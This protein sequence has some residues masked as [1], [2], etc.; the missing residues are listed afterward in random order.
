[1]DDWYIAAN[2]MKKQAE[3]NR[4]KKLKEKQELEKFIARFS[5]NASKAKQATSRQKQLEKLDIADIQ[6]SSRRD[7]SIMFKPNREIGN[8]VL[9]VID[10]YKSYEDNK[11]LNGVSFKAEKSDKIAIIGG[12]G[13]GK[14]TLLEI[15]IG[16]LEPDSGTIKW[17]QTVIPTY[18]PQNTTE[19]LNAKE[20]LYEWI[21][22]HNK[23]WHIDEH[24]ALVE[25]NIE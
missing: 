20:K 24:L 7:P 25:K 3:L 8:E 2:L 16:N 5:A 18:F 9:E 17:G 19:I 1:V 4:N 10:I 15:I 11:V 12:N 13:V 14:T 23:D 21:Q 22:G 6:V